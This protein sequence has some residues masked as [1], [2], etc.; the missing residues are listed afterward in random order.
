[1]N[2]L[3]IIILAFD[4]FKSLESTIKEINTLNLGFVPSIVI[5]TS[6]NASKLCQEMAI[7]QSVENRN[8]R[9]YFQREPF[10]AAA[11]LE[12]CELEG[13]SYV[14]YM[15]ADGET[16]ASCIPSMVKKIESESLDIVSTSRWI[17][18]G[19]FEGYGP[20]KFCVAFLAQKVC[21]FIYHSQ[22]T[23]F[24]YGYRIYRGELLKKLVFKEKKHPFFLESLLVPLSLNY[25]IG[26]V[27][28]KYSNRTEGKSVA[29]V[30]VLL[31][32]L[33]PIFQVRFRNKVKMVK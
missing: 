9:V 13:S 21:R 28:A 27:P 8:V 23:E 29:N 3:S 15:S 1:M 5:S 25:K 24:T 32:Y 6:T 10:V 18:G 20:V 14:I 33:R 31:T 2:K 4:E 30:I 11:V 7:Q 16:P 26:E 22:L 12:A 17:D 19:G